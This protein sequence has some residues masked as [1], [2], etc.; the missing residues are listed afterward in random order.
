[1]LIVGEASIN[2]ARVNDPVLSPHQRVPIQ[3]PAKIQV[4]R[5]CLEFVRVPYAPDEDGSK[6]Y[7]ANARHNG[8]G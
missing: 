7:P 8:A 1:M 4:E 5:T 2:G 3:A 6:L